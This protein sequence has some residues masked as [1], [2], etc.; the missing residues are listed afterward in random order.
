MKVS[1]QTTNIG[2][3]IAYIVIIY[4]FHIYIFG[5]NHLSQVHLGKKFFKVAIRPQR[6]DQLRLIV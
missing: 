2:N 6:E 5:T 4:C 1:I 3:V